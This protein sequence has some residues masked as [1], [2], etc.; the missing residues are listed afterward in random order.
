MIQ[1]AEQF[2]SL[3]NT[4]GSILGIFTILRWIRTILAKITGRPP[5]A[6]SSSLTPANF[7]AF[8]GRP[9]LLPDGSHAPASHHPKPSKKPFLVFLL[10][11]FGLP[12]LMGKLIR[13][14]AKS[15][16]A[17]QAAQLRQQGLLDANGMPIP[18]NMPG[19]AEVLDPSKLEFC[20]LLFDFPPPNHQRDN[21]H[22]SGIDLEVKKGD[23]IAV[24][25][26][27]DPMGQPSEW[28]RCRARDGRVGWLPG[29]YLEAVTRKADSERVMEITSG[30]QNG[31]SRT[32][33]MT[34]I[35]N[36][37]REAVSASKTDPTTQATDVDVSAERSLKGQFY[38]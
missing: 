1:V 31:S 30:S 29:I 16:E 35:S 36:A 2:S 14:L 38:S 10:A 25:S 8:E 13:V 37:V 27:M 24:L 15:Q 23:L 3:R 18:I 4:L 32:G 21:T 20:R 11:A 26:K 7:A 34:S 9:I 17:A 5:P 33:T 19:Q 12:Y 22:V 6:S 28:W